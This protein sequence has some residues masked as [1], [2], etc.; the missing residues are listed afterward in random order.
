MP[1]PTS[2]A[3]VPLCATRAQGCWPDCTVQHL[4]AA[5]VNDQYLPAIPEI[6]ASV[7][8]GAVL[9][10]PHAFTLQSQEQWLWLW[11]G[12]R[13]RA[14]EQS[15]SCGSLGQTEGEFGVELGPRRAQRYW[16]RL[17]NIIT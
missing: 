5:S 16:K 12:G 6:S 15:A 13:R 14:A 4:D 2:P 3:V 17:P 10:S 1:A 7:H 9:S 8:L 11:G